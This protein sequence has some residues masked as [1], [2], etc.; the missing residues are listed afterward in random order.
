M[1]RREQ[2]A[3]LGDGLYERLDDFFVQFEDNVAENESS[4]PQSNVVFLRNAIGSL[5]EVVGGDNIVEHL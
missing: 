2:N 5:N 1:S 4:Q 3:A